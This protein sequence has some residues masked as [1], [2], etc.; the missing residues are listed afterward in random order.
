[1]A[2]KKELK[3]EELEKVN[4][5]YSE[6]DFAKYYCIVWASKKVQHGEAGW[7]EILG[8]YETIEAATQGG[9][10]WAVE[11]T[12]KGCYN[13]SYQP[14]LMLYDHVLEAYTKYK[15]YPR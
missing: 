10:D 4:G 2:E 1:M 8:P 6:R 7:D 5:G 3:Q 15:Y 14:V 12:A 11:N 9:L 13:I